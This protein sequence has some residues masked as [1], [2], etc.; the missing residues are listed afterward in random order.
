MMCYVKSVFSLCFHETLGIQGVGGMN[1]IQTHLIV[2]HKSSMIIVKKQKKNSSMMS[3]EIEMFCVDPKRV[4]F[5]RFSTM[6]T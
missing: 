5:V 4:K 2:S 1:A 6:K 3:K